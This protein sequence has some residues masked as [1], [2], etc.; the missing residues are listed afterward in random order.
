MKGEA[1]IAISMLISNSSVCK[2]KYIEIVE[3]ADTALSNIKKCF[4]ELNIRNNTTI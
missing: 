4:H 3:N 1:L 2:K